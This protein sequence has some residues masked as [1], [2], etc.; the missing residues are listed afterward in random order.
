M[1][2]ARRHNAAV[3]TFLA[4]LR[5]SG[6]WWKPSRPLQ[7]QSDWPAHASFMDALVKIDAGLTVQVPVPT[8]V[9]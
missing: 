5:R 4:V 7:E 2:S 6:P 8:R 9:A 1:S 3:A